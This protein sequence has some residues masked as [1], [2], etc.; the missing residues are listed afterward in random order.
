MS[1]GRVPSKIFSCLCPFFPFRIDYY[2]KRQSILCF[3]S[4]SAQHKNR[5]MNTRI[6][7]FFTNNYAAGHICLVG[8]NDAMGK[9]IRDGQAGLTPDKKPSKWSHSFLMGERRQDGQ[10][11]IFE[12]ALRVDS[13]RWQVQNGAMES[14]LMKWCVDKIEYACVLGLD[15]SPSQQSQLI[16]TALKLAYGD[17]H[18]S[19]SVGELFGTLWAIITRSLNKKNVFDDKYAVQCATY[20]RMIYQSINRDPLT[21]A[22]DLTNTSPEKLY[23]STMFTIR[24]EMA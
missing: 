15:F 14:R 18:L 16:K 20:V 24:K 11:Y 23:Q 22:T 5:I 1:F 10:I 9:L 7:N 3:E 4:I 17:S 21:G 6:F 2:I 19:Y 8:A 13:E 12:S